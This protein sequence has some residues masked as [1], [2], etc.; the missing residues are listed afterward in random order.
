SP[1]STAVPSLNTGVTS[2]LYEAPSSTP[3]ISGRVLS[4]VKRTVSALPA[5]SVTT[6]VYSSSS[7]I[8]VPEVNASPFSIAVPS[9]NAGVTSVLY[10]APSS[11]S[12][13]S[14]RVLSTTKL[15]V[16]ALPAASVTMSIYASSSVITVPEVN[17]APLSVA[18]P[19]LNTGVTSVLYEAPSS[20]SVISGRVLSTTK[21]T[22]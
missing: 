22:V 11:T 8:T 20:T 5:A 14:G 10:E 18:V 1:F 13:I 7:A 16:S 4:M 12:V 21:L 6:S 2:V 3:V 17:A 19:S 15:T 9:L